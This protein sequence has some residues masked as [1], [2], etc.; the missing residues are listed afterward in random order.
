MNRDEFLQNLF[1]MYPNTFTEIN[2]QTWH[3][4]YCIIFGNK[5]ID[6]DKLFEIY[7]TNYQS[8]STPPSPAWFKENLSTCIIKPDICAALKHS[9]EIKKDGGTPPPPYIKQQITKLLQKVSI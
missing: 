4:A 9:I 8:V 5:K 1:S 7:V 2:L 6:Y 3:K